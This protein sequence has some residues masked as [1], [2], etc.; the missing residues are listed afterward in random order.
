MPLPK[1]KTA[2]RE[3]SAL[4]G[5]VQAVKKWGQSWPENSMC[6]MLA[7]AVLLSV[8]GPRMYLS[9]TRCSPFRTATVYVSSGSQYM[10]PS[11]RPLGT[12]YAR[13]K[14]H[15]SLD[16]HFHIT[17][18]KKKKKKA[19]GTIYIYTNLEKRGGKG[20]KHGRKRRHGG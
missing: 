5:C 19:L 10:S 3:E 8:R 1:K 13:R 2:R 18:Q 20:H 11:S 14:F 9:P 17:L 4:V 6:Q 15:P 12:S 16:A 7:A